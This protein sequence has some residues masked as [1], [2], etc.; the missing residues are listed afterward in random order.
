MEAA[1]ENGTMQMDGKWINIHV[2]QNSMEFLNDSRKSNC[3]TCDAVLNLEEGGRFP[4][5]REILMSSS[6]YFMAL[7]TKTT[8]SLV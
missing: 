8:T 3:V 4:V 2:R 7:F 6:Q 1:T 5:H